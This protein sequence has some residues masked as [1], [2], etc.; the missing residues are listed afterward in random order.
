VLRSFSVIWL[1][2]IIIALSWSYSKK[3]LQF[4]YHKAGEFIIFILFGPALVMG[5]YFIQTRIFPDL[6]SF[7]LSLPFAFLTTAI[8]FANEV[9]DFSDD[10]KM[11]KFTW[12]K[13]CG[14]ARAFLAYNI[15][16]VLAFLS[17]LAN[18]FSGYLSAWALASFGCITLAYRAAR[19]LQ[20]YP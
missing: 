6:K 13:V 14:P 16:I 8:L 11:G 20:R 12:V 10:E 17:I 9:P 1:Y 2:A 3:P 15:L 4:S 7:T 19:I 18:I 5:G